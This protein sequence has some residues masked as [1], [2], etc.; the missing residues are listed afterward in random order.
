MTEIV[1]Y[2]SE[3]K[4]VPTHVRL[5]NAMLTHSGYE[6]YLVGG[7]VRDHVIGRVPNDYDITTNA[8]PEQIIEQIGRAHV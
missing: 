4:N 3:F 7:C 8:T 2:S 6:A 5:V 1:K